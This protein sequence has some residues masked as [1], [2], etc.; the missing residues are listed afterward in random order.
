MSLLLEV[1]KIKT[2]FISYLMI[3]C[4]ID[5]QVLTKVHTEPHLYLGIHL[6]RQLL[7]HREESVRYNLPQKHRPTPALNQS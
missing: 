1:S 4:S 6:P 3:A 7:S 2:R 5:D